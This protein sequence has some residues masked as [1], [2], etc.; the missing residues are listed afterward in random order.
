MLRVFFAILA[1]L[2][3]LSAA[4]AQEPFQ[5]TIMHTNDTHTYHEPDADGNG[6]VAIMKTVIEQIRAEA[7]NS[8]L[9][10][11]G[12]RFTGTLFH[13]RYLGA[14]NALLMNLLGF[15]AMTLGN[16]E[17]DNGEQVLADFIDSVNFPIVAANIE[18]PPTSPLDGKILPYV[19]IDMNGE[20]V[21]IIGF[22]TPETRFLARVSQDVIF[23]EDAVEIV[24]SIVDELT[25]E[26]INKIILLAH[27]SYQSQLELASQVTGVDVM[28]GGD[29]ETLLSNIYAVAGGRYSA[30]VEGPYPTV[31]TSPS[32]EPVLVVQA[33][34]HNRYLGRLN[35]TFDA[36]G[37]A[38][39]WDGDN[40]LMSRYIPADPEVQA[41]L[42]ELRQPL[43]EM[44]AEVVGQTAVYL[45]GDRN[46]CRSAECNMGNLIA[47]AIRQDTGVQIAFMNGGGIRASIPVATDRPE[48]LLL[49]EPL[50]VTFGDVMTVL[51]F[52]NRIST[53]E[54]TGADVLAALENGVSRVGGDTGTGR[55]LQ[56]SGLR[57]SWDGSRAPG[58]R[59]VSAEILNEDGSFSPID[60]EA[61]YRVA[62]NDFLRNGGDEFYMFRDN[63][64]NARD[65]GKELDVVLM[66][67]LAANSP[68]MPEIE[69][70]ITRIDE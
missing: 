26:G 41:L 34:R 35:V 67:Y 63:A 23:G 42:E 49:P 21:A 20:Q 55:F 4:V 30:V 62:A 31:V 33:F 32:G 24:Q 27:L 14:D 40:I 47:D 12:D 28:I 39:S 68:V 45:D 60:P 25:A 1:M 70:R 22:T 61:V 65:D 64:I 50:D 54:L 3:V 59:I 10:D 44:R 51:P 69:G 36:N 58:E 8:L 66:E 2:V 6:G 46:E 53:F 48:V 57:Y 11:A 29:S 52:R 38:V 9:L 43:D 7:P 18:I 17:F 13:S 37:V 19:V 5:L 16:H 15:D 56:V